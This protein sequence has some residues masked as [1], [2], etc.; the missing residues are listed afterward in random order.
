MTLESILGYNIITEELENQC[1]KL[2]DHLI[3][4]ITEKKKHDYNKNP[5]NHTIIDEYLLCLSLFVLQGLLFS[6]CA[7]SKGVF[8]VTISI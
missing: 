1:I 3:G 6:L 2:G 8:Q 7:R 5:V 4:I